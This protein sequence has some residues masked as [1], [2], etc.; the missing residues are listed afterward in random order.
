M[1]YKW[2]HTIYSLLSLTVFTHHNAFEIY[3]CC[4][5]YQWFIPFNEEQRSIARMYHCLFTHSP[6]DRAFELFLVGVTINSA[7][8]TFHV[9]VFVW[10]CVSISTIILVWTA[11]M[12]W[13]DGVAYKQQKFIS[14]SLG[15]WKFEIRVPV[16]DGWE[17]TEF[18]GAMG[19]F[20][21][22]YKHPIPG[23]W[24]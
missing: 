23:S 14:H 8:I 24:W 15:G 10:T 3:S 20:L 6:V 11:I 7:A 18:K 1:S 13:V 5:T 17:G 22:W 19:N 4:C 2:N 21:S 12:E 9:Q 16:G